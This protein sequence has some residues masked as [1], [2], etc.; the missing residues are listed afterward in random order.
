MGQ[1][2]GKQPSFFYMWQLLTL[3]PRCPRRHQFENTGRAA[4]PST[5]A[6]QSA[7]CFESKAASPFMAV[8]RGGAATLV[9]DHW[10]GDRCKQLHSPGTPEIT[11]ALDDKAPRFRGGASEFCGR[12]ATPINLRGDWRWSNVYISAPPRT[13]FCLERLREKHGRPV[14]FQGGRV[15]CMRCADFPVHRLLWPSSSR[16][17]GVARVGALAVA[18]GVSHACAPPRFSGVNVCVGSD[19]RPWPPGA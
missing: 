5:E 1:E 19:R 13:A 10:F 3:G 12:A 16:R 8:D 4:I 14:K 6:T 2:A 17:Q 11:V 7:R 9:T 18:E 15:Y